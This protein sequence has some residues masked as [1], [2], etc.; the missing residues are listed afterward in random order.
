MKHYASKM[1]KLKLKRKQQN[2]SSIH[3]FIQTYKKE[4]PTHINSNERE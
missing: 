1:K 3:N 4:L 2:C